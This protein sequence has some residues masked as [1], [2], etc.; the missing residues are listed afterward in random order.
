[1]PTILLEHACSLK[2]I[3]QANYRNYRNY[4]NIRSKC[5]ETFEPEY[6]Y[7]RYM[8]MH[9]SCVWMRARKLGSLRLTAKLFVE[10]NRI[11]K[12]RIISTVAHVRACFV[13]I[14]VGPWERG[15][16][17]ERERE[18]CCRFMDSDKPSRIDAI[19]AFHIILIVLFYAPYIS[20]YVL[21]LC[22]CIFCSYV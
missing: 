21:H 8:R 1:M 6:T 18:R 19:S 9:V 17:T 20:R 11:G 10:V 2:Y 4:R 15:R 13:Q 3:L 7:V 5:L 14:S 22:V 16:H 12:Q